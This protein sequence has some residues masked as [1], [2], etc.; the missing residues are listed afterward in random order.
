MGGN[1]IV[2]LQKET[3]QEKN[4]PGL[5]REAC[6]VSSQ[7]ANQVMSVKVEEVSDM[8]EEAVHV[9]I[10]WHAIKSECEVSRISL[11]C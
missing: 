4:I 2:D 11:S 10:P 9:P 3:A 8:Q 5:C 1:H 7:D 6:P